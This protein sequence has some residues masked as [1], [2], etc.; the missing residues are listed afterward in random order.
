MKKKVSIYIRVFALIGVLFYAGYSVYW[1]AKYES[2][3]KVVIVG[4][5]TDVRTSGQVG[6]IVYYKFEVDGCEYNG[7]DS[8]GGSMKGFSY[9]PLDCITISYSVDDPNINK[10]EQLGCK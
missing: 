7:S 10:I 6:F 3:E 5:I 9:S 1:D 2:S 8:Q 4:C